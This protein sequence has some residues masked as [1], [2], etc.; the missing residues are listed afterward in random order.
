MKPRL[1]GGATPARHGVAVVGVVAPHAGGHDEMRVRRDATATVAVRFGVDRPCDGGTMRGDGGP[2]VITHHRDPVVGF[3]GLRQ[4][5]DDVPGAHRVRG[6]VGSRRVSLTPDAAVLLGPARMVGRQL[7]PV[8]D[9]IVTVPEVEATQRIAP[10][11]TG[12]IEIIGGDRGVGGATIG[13]EEA[14]A[15]GGDRTD[16]D[17]TAGVQRGDGVHG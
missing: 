3:A 4:R 16:A 17:R 7:E 12:D 15:L 2:R 5:D 6:E 1:H 11:L 10:R 8:R 9:K 13:V 14:E